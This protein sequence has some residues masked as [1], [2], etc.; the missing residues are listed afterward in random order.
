MNER[1][2]KL[3]D[4]SHPSNENMIKGEQTSTKTSEDLATDDNRVEIFRDT[5]PA[6]TSVSEPSPKKIRAP[7]PPRWRFVKEAKKTA[8]Y[9]SVAAGSAI[10]GKSAEELG[11]KYTP[12]KIIHSRE[13][14]EREVGKL[15]V[16]EWDVDEELLEGEFAGFP[17]N[18]LERDQDQAFKEHFQR[19]ERNRNSNCDGPEDNIGSCREGDTFHDDEDL[20][21]GKIPAMTESGPVGD[22]LNEQGENESTHYDCN[23]T[24]EED[25]NDSG[26]TYIGDQNDGNGGNDGM[27]IAVHDRDTVLQRRRKWMIDC[28]LPI[29]LLFLIAAVVLGVLLEDEPSPDYKVEPI[30]FNVVVDAP[31]TI[32]P[33]AFP[34]G[35]PTISL[36]M[37]I[38]NLP[39][40]APSIPALPPPSTLIS[41]P[42]YGVTLFIPSTL[43]PPFTYTGAPSATSSSTPSL[44]PS[45]TPSN[46]P[47]LFSSNQLSIHSSHPSFDPLREPTKMP[48]ISPTSMSPSMQ[49]LPFIGVCPIAFTPIS[50][51]D[52]GTKVESE[53]IVYECA[54]CYYCGSYGFE[55]GLTTSMLWKEAWSIVGTCFG[56]ARPTVLPTALPSSSPTL[57]PSSISSS[58]PSFDPTSKPSIT[59][60]ASFS[61][62]GQPFVFVGGCPITFSPLSYYSIGTTVES[63]GIVYECV[64][65]SCGTYGFEPGLTT[66]M[67]WKDA[68]IIVGTCFGTLTPTSL[69]SFFPSS[70]L[71]DAP[72]IFPTSN[73]TALPSDFPSSTPSAV[74]TSM[75]SSNP[76]LHPSNNPSNQPS[77]RPSLFPSAG[78]SPLQSS[79]PSSDPSD[80]PSIIPSIMQT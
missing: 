7:S 29:L 47:T 5:T 42:P 72:S 60:T 17:K 66:S 36:P 44:P 41:Q 67:L 63:E 55:P 9:S 48:S 52:I 70:E 3:T 12:P 76:S 64:K 15:H 61:P 74:M 6:P 1:S 30:S 2:V 69:P 21:V 34:S 46:T 11:A 28:I 68:W 56:T 22:V 19:N 58:S 79:Q 53:G 73:P 14:I 13:I 20:E 50:Y 23:K 32:K 39:S 31:V 71:S 57:V 33:S 16:R 80:L 40:N 65:F 45:A 43:V 49:P 26:Q 78:P 38:T 8:G 59:P 27:P 62:S 75:P 4:I 25:N 24:I 10:K 35:E 54:S 37:Q 18:D 77:P 51:Y